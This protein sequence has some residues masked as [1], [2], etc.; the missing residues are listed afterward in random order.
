[1][2][3]NTLTVEIEKPIDIVFDFTVNPNNTPRWVPSVLEEKATDTK[4]KV[5]TVYNQIVKGSSGETKKSAL[6]VTGFIKNKMLDFHLVNGQYT[7]SYR[8]EEIPTGTRM[9]YSEEN[10]IDGEIESPMTIENLQALKK[11]IE[12]A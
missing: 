6:V 5:G 2:K 11:L 10:G 8:Y 12:E 7:C 4:V 1:M 9:I 3:K